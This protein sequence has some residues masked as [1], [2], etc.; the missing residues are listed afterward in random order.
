LI[1]G[2]AG[3]GVVISG[4]AFAILAVGLIEGWYA[5]PDRLSE[6]LAVA[7]V[8]ITTWTAGV[9]CERAP[10]RWAA[11]AV[12]L[13]PMA[14]AVVGYLLVEK[15]EEHHGTGVAPT[16]VAAVVA[17]SAALIGGA[18][19]VAR[20]TRP[21]PLEGSPG[22]LGTTGVV[23]TFTGVAAAFGLSATGLASGAFAARWLE[24]RDFIPEGSAP[25]ALAFLAALGTTAA[26][27]TV[28]DVAGR[29][30]SLAIAIAGVIALVGLWEVAQSVETT[31][32]E[33]ADPPLILGTAAMFALLL[34]AGARLQRRRTAR[35]AETAH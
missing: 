17:L 25:V 29:W 35:T 14:V 6:L 15:T 16:T 34:S 28:A 8:A 18:A 13:V 33:G 5:M 31:G 23:T 2:L 27:A 9:L 32:A 26:G 20:R 12:A 11:A 4:L 30:A 1:W 22:V 19:Y 3:L 10:G 24:T 7:V 21:A